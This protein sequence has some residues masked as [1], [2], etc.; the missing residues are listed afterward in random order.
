MKDG[1]PHNLFKKTFWDNRVMFSEGGSS[2]V[3]IYNLNGEGKTPKMDYVIYEQ[4]SHQ[5]NLD[6]VSMEL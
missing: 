3:T 4:K 2:I 5:L 6:Y 1:G